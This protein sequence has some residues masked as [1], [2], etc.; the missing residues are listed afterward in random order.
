MQKCHSLYLVVQAQS[1]KLHMETALLQQVQRVVMLGRLLRP[2]AGQ[3]LRR[4]E[5]L[6]LAVPEHQTT[7]LSKWPQTGKQRMQVHRTGRP[8]HRRAQRLG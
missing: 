7:R 2:L 3:T 1:V 8:H 4:M 5:F 6:Q